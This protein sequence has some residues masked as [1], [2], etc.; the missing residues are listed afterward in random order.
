MSAVSGLVI[1]PFKAI[2]KWCSASS[3]RLVALLVVGVLVVAAALAALLWPEFR[4]GGPPAGGAEPLS[5][6]VRNLALIVAG[7]V[8][9]ILTVW[10]IRVSE[11]QAEIAR[12]GLLNERFQRGAE[13]LGSPVVSVRMGGIHA[14]DD[15]ARERPELYHIRV[16]LLLCAFV[17]HPTGFETNPGAQ[18]ISEGATRWYK[19]RPDVRAAIEAV[20]HRSEIGLLVEEES[21]LPKKRILDLQ[22]S[23][24]RGASLAGSDFAGANFHEAQLDRVQF[25][26]ANLSQAT[27]SNAHLPRAHLL[28]ADLSNAQLSGAVMAGAYA[29]RAKFCAAHMTNDMT[30]ANLSWAD[31]TGTAVGTADL[32]G[33]DLTECNLSGASFSE[34]RRSTLHSSGV[35]ES[36]TVYAL[37]T[38]AQLDRAVCAPGQPPSLAEGTTDTE[39]GLPLVWRGRNRHTCEDGAHLPCG[40]TSCKECSPC[41]RCKEHKARGSSVGGAPAV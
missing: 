23:D 15:L 32:T 28:H 22:G 6:T 29:A 41:E 9:V 30:N 14:L 33:A 17:R 39:T 7:I 34:A 18:P 2:V 16:I 31:L 35:H 38:Q 10:R 24:L 26:N 1:R 11:Q 21:E 20:A 12:L 19:L 13:M 3:G 8:A 4:V 36:R 27:F 25:A 5:A 40:N 37:L